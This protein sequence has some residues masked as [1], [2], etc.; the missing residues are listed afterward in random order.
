MLTPDLAQRFRDHHTVLRGG[1]VK[2]ADTYLRASTAFFTWHSKQEGMPL[3]RGAVEK[4]LIFLSLNGCTSNSTRASRLSGL[5]TVC[6]FLVE[7]GE[8]SA[9]P[10]EGV[11]T[12]RFHTHAAQKF[13]TAELGHLW[14]TCDVSTPLGLRDRCILMLFSATGMRRE[15]MATLTIDRLEFGDRCGSVRI[16]GKGSKQRTVSFENKHMIDL[17]KQWLFGA[18]ASAA[19]DGVTTLFVGLTGPSKGSPLGLKGMH[20]AIKR[21]GRRFGMAEAK[22][23][24]HKLRSTYATAL[25][26]EG[27]GVDIKVISILMG[28]SDEKTTWKYIAISKRAQNQGRLPASYWAEVEKHAEAAQ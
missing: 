23:F 24:L 5:R 25:Y 6:K 18:R 11:P 12:P 14:S 7:T 4:W 27:K 17:L 22:V 2:T 20:E 13:T 28:H 26:D 1:S 21:A 16:L 3:G 15:E 9:N 19:R 8:L 10:T